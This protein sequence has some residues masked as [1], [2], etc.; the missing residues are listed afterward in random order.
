MAEAMLCAECGIPAAV[1]IVHP[2]LSRMAIPACGFHGE[3][4]AGLD[5]FAI[6][7]PEAEELLETHALLQGYVVPRT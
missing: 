4:E 2:H 1:L 3:L 5:V 6:G 7:T